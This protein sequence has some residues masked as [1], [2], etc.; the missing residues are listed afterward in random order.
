[1]GATSTSS[2]PRSRSSAVS[3]ALRKIAQDDDRVAASGHA[4][5]RDPVRHAGHGGQKDRVTKAVRTVQQ[6][7]VAVEETVLDGARKDFTGSQFRQKTR[8]P[9]LSRLVNVYLH[10]FGPN[11][12]DF[13]RLFMTTHTIFV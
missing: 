3:A 4:Q 7:Q 9:V 6:R 2:A 1:M 13:L 5:C 10:P 11:V 12:C 8:A